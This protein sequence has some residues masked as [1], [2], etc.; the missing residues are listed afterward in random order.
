MGDEVKA[1]EAARALAEEES[2]DLTE[3]EGTGADGQVTKPDVERAIQ[4]RDADDG[5]DLDEQSVE[6]EEAAEE[7]EGEKL[8]YAEFNPKLGDQ[9]RLVLHDAEGNSRLFLNS[10]PNSRLLTGT[11]FEEF[12]R[13]P[14]PPTPEHP[15]GFKYLVKGKE[16]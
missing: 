3:V 5:E 7:A 13:I 9:E 10:D 12:N 4:A 1:S 11:Q 15:N 16:A 8:F 6:E 2:I 14:H